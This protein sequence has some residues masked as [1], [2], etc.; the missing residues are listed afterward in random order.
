MNSKVLP[1]I[2][3]LLASFVT[4]SA[5]HAQSNNYTQT[6]LVSN[7]PGLAL[8][9]DDDLLHPWGMAASA[10]QPFRIAANPLSDPSSAHDSPGATKAIPRRA[11]DDGRAG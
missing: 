9:V 11:H 8:A 10:N 6:N 4:N 2:F 1:G 3:L 7:V 5:A